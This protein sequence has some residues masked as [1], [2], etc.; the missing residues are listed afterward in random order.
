[1]LAVAASIALCGPEISG[2]GQRDLSMAAPQPSCRSKSIY[3]EA[4][5]YSVPIR[6]EL[7]SNRCDSLLVSGTSEYQLPSWQADHLIVVAGMDQWEY[8]PGQIRVIQ[9]QLP[10]GAVSIGHQSFTDDTRLHT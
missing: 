10:Q 1:V 5:V 6:T 2:A 3:R 4:A 7:N 8:T 9:H